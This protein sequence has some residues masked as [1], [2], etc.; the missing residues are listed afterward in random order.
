MLSRNIFLVSLLTVGSTYSVGSLGVLSDKSNDNLSLIGAR[1]FKQN[2]AKA[3]RVVTCK[4]LPCV[5]STGSLGVL[6]DKSNDNLSLI[7]ARIA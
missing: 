7:G 3:K 1:I 2:I 4:N 5:H 6:R